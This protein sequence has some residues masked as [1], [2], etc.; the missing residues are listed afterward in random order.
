MLSV[1]EFIAAVGRTSS[2][3]TPKS[4]LDYC[5]NLVVLDSDTDSFRL[6]H[7]TVR[8]YDIPQTDSK[9]LTDNHLKVL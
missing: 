4:V 3:L 2:G 6:S 1:S 7:P 8:E 5:C 9:S